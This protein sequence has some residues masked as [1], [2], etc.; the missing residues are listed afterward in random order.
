MQIDVN[1]DFRSDAN[2]GDP[3]KTSPTLR[4]YHKLLWDKA[5][6]GGGRL[7]LDAPLGGPY[8]IHRAAADEIVLT[9]DAAIPTFTRW[10]RAAAIVSGTTDEERAHFYDTAYKIGAMMVF[11]GKRID[12]KWTLNQA[13]GCL[14]RVDDRLDLTLECIRRRYQSDGGANP[15]GD[16]LSRYWNFFDLFTDFDGYIEFFLLQDLVDNGEVRFFTPFDNFAGSGLPRD[17]DAYRGYM[18]NAL[19]FIEA[20]NRRISDWSESFNGT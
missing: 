10:D 14:R 3:D 6:P 11:P 5:L 7:T 18:E 12:G 8:L 16:V 20:R 2:G 4:Q 9:S 15:L 19:A 1:F 17:P 13:R